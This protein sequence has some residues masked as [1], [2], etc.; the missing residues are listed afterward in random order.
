[1]LMNAAHG[2]PSVSRSL[3]FK[4]RGLPSLACSIQRYYAWGII[5]IHGI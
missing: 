5:G 1:M 4:S 3:G 2:L